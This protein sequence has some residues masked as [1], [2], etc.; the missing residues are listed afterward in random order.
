MSLEPLMTKVRTK[1]ILSCMGLTVACLL[2]T[3][4]AWAFFVA[5][6]VVGKVAQ[7]QSPKLVLSGLVPAEATMVKLK[8]EDGKSFSFPLGQIQTD[9]TREIV[10]DGKLGRHRY[11]GSVTAQVNGEQVSSALAFETVVAAPIVLQVDRQ[12]LDLAAHTLVF[13]SNV[14]LKQAQLVVV[15][16]DDHRFFEE[17]FDVSSVAPNR[18]ITLR[19][20]GGKTDDVM[21]LELRVEDADGFFKAIALTPWSVSVPHEEVLFSSNSASIGPQEEGKLQASLEAI[22]AI[23]ERFQ[24][25]QGVQLFI[26]GHTDTVGKP[27]HN[28]Q[29]SRL[30]AQAIANWFVAHNVPTPVYFEGFG[31]SSLRVKTGDDVPEAKNRRGDYILAVDLPTLRSQAHGWKRL[32]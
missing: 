14:A 20:Q 26:A 2:H 8:R 5:V 6:E 21:R 29:L 7:G 1:I 19:W 24:Q 32:K 22:T 16:V 28:A 18:P 11:E 10:L 31:E 9:E 30:R 13:S 23:L 15:D 27:A 17:Q 4:V 12:Q 3:A 25:I